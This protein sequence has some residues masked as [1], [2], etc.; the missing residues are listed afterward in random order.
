MRVHFNIFIFEGALWHPF[1]QC[2]LTSLHLIVHFDIFS[3]RVHF[4]I[5]IFESALWYL[6][7]ES[8]LWHLYFESVI[9]HLY[10]WECTLASL[11]WECNL[12]SLFLRVQFGIF[13][14]DCEL[15][16]VNWGNFILLVI[17]GGYFFFDGAMWGFCLNGARLEFLF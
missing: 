9:W 13:I 7:F 8:A 2:T 10:F 3:L 1:L 5:F 11:F 4:G 16:K 6:Y 14:F 17:H 15:C 12:T